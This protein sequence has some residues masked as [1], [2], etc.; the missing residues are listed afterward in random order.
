MKPVT[1]TPSDA[2][3]PRVRPPGDERLQR[4]VRV[5]RIIARLNIGGPAYH[6]SLLSGRMDRERYPTLL[7]HGE[8]G[9]GEES[10]EGLARDEGCET[11]LIR[12][13]RARGKARG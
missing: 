2:D 12:Y 3:Q 11:M 6:V 7:V 8:V 10:F 4:P 9:P 1:T 13:A 5:L